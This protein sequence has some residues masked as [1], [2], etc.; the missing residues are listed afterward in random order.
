MR[1]LDWETE[2]PFQDVPVLYVYHP[3]ASAVPGAMPFA[4][5]SYPGFVGAITGM[6]SS[7]VAISEIS[8]TWADYGGKIASRGYPFHY[9]L[10]DILEFD[11]DKSAALTRI[12]NAG[13]TVHK[14][15]FR[16]IRV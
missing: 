8:W 6:S 10:R 15:Q 12:Y 13:N 14:S 1:A 5:F 16:N 4:S 3:D 11:I 9:L 7:Q 2:G